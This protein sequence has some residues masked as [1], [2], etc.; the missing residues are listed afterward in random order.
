MKVSTNGLTVHIQENAINKGG[1]N[2][3]VLCNGYTFTKRISKKDV[4]F[5]GKLEITIQEG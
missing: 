1:Y 5:L 4:S 2:L 3:V